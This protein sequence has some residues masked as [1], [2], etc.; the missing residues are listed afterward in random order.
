[1]LALPVLLLVLALIFLVLNAI[2][3]LPAWPAIL[4]VILRLLVGGLVV[5]FLWSSAAAADER[6]SDPKIKPEKVSREERLCFDSNQVPEPCPTFHLSV[7]AGGLAGAAT[8][9]DAK[10][11]PTFTIRTLSDL[12]RSKNGPKVA[13]RLGLEALPGEDLTSIDGATVFKAFDGSGT[14]IQPLGEKLLF[15]LYARGGVASRLS[16]T[17]EPV[18]RLPG[19]FDFGVDLHTNDGD[20]YLQAGIGPDQRLSGEWAQAVHLEGAVKIGERS[21]VKAWI[22]VEVI[23]AL[24]LARYGFRTPSRDWWAISVVAGR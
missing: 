3:K 20:N 16:T 14:V 23:R 19:Y 22:E 18:A 12:T 7:R 8:D 9:V 17:R 13:F 4:C 11:E 15:N 24:N 10:V 2:G 21:G 1:M 6:L 5:G